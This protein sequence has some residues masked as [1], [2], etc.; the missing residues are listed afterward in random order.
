MKYRKVAIT[1]LSIVSLITVATIAISN[2]HSKQPTISSVYP[3][4]AILTNA[5]KSLSSG[6][7]TVT[8]VPEA[9]VTSNQPVVSSKQKVNK[10]MQSTPI[11]SSTVVPAPQSP[12]TVT[13][14]SVIPLDDIGNQDCVYTY[15]DG[16]TYQFRYQTINP[17]GS[18]I[19]D[20][21]GKNGYWA[22]T[23]HTDG[24]CDDS[25]IGQLKN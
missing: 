17:Q 24:I 19:T 6:S 9:T 18:W 14:Y 2:V 22:P 25:V 21:Q 1:T 10:T 13:N 12:V 11:S 23:I 5:K 4:S 16:T 20:G 7:T 8:S 3:S 15:S